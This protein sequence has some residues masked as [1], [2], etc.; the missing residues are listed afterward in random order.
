MECVKACPTGALVEEEIE[1][2][3]KKLMRVNFLAHKCDK[4]GQCVEACPIGIKRVDDDFPY[5]KGH[6]VL[7]QKCIE[8][9]PIEIISLPGV[10]DK[11]KKEVKSKRPRTLLDFLEG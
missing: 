4:C 5:S 10:V 2:N 9:C 11:P 8:V 1:I 3:G 7:C 6:C